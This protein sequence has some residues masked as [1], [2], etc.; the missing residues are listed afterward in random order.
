MDVAAFCVERGLLDG[1]IRGLTGDCVA[2]RR[3]LPRVGDDGTGH[4][5][6]RCCE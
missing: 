4:G 6:P 5:A 3:P 2:A 1:L